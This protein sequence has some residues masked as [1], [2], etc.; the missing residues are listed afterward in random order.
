MS[1]YSYRVPCT[2]VIDGDT[3]E[4]A[5]MDFGFG[6]R[7]YPISDKPRDQI[8]FRLAGINAYGTTFREADTEAD[9]QKGLAAKAWL[10]ARVAGKPVRFRSIR[11]GTEDDFGRFLALIFDDGPDD[12]PLDPQQSL[13]RELLVQGFAVVSKYPDGALFDGQGFPRE[14]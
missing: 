8:R 9:K 10:T 5:Y 1:L 4:L 14:T 2:K 7:E 6:R 3:V 11:G 12:A 13:N